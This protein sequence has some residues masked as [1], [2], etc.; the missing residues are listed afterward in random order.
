MT[1]HKPQ[2][3]ALGQLV[4][5]SKQA[6]SQDLRHTSKTDC[7]VIIGETALICDNRRARKRPTIARTMRLA[8]YASALLMN[9]VA[10]YFVSTF[11]RN[12]VIEWPRSSGG[13]N[14]PREQ[15]GDGRGPPNVEGAEIHCGELGMWFSPRTCLSGDETDSYRNFLLE[16]E[17]S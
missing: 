7:L 3:L 13:K 15:D 1:E 9:F 2:H 12:Q 8:K 6:V 4:R 17:T 16:S 14:S 11:A 10:D 5:R